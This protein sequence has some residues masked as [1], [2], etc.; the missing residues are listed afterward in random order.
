[1]L[2]QDSAIT[3]HIVQDILILCLDVGHGMQLAPPGQI[4][5]LKKAI[6]IMSML[7]HR[8]VL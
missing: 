2:W 7:V 4:S 5:H 3:I 8:K 1:M 6:Q